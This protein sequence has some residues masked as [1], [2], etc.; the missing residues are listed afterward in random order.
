MSKPAE[1]FIPDCSCRCGG[2]NAAIASANGETS[3]LRKAL[4]WCRAT[5]DDAIAIGKIRYKDDFACYSPWPE[6]RARLAEINKVL[7]AL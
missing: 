7:E 5:I 6:L 1:D 4:S 2:C 3:A